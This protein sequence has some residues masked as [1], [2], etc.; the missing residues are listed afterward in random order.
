PVERA[1]RGGRRLRTRRRVTLL[2]GALA[3]AVVAVAAGYPALARSSAAPTAP[4]TGQRSAPAPHPSP[5]GGDMVVTA[6]PSGKATQA[7]GGLTDN[8]GQIAEG[9]VGAMK[10][11]MSVVAPGQQSPVP[12]DSC[13]TIAI[14]LGGR[15]I[16]GECNDIPGS[17]GSGLAAGQPAAFTGLSN[18]GTTETT[19]GEVTQDVAYFIVN[20]TDGQQLKLIPVTA[21]GHR[22]IAW[23][24]PLS[25]TIQYVV[26]HLGAPYNDSGQ[27]A[28]AVPFQRPGQPPVFGRWQRDGQSAPSPDVKV[29]GQG[30]A[31]GH[32]WKVTAYTGPWGTCFVADPHGS[33]C[34]PANLDTTTIL[35]W[36]PGGPFSTGGW[37][38]GSAAP[39]VASLRVTFSNGKTGT[40]RPVGVGNEDLFAV[41]ADKVVAP[42]GWTA[43]DASGQQVGAG[44]VSSFSATSS[45]GP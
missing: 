2:A 42:T 15:D 44:S 7:P 22:Y 37:A 1:K 38:F 31:G 3:L 6:G 41:P 8:T 20:F 28:V 18:D 39:G 40:V 26:A 10:W 4:A 29:I 5:Y 23:M 19:V 24:A 45:A 21:G 11:R 33:E 36:G 32:A 12:G 14:F 25:M 9:A 34:V 13:Y 16:Q 43:Y 35:G 27:I 17:L 30:T